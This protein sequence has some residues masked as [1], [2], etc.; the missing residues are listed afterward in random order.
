MATATSLQQ[1][2]E[3]VRLHRT[4]VSLALRNDPRIAAATR[5]RVQ[6]AARQ[7]G[8]RPNPLVVALMK[9]RRS[10]QRAATETIAYLTAYPTRDGW[11]EEHSQRADMFT[12]ARARAAELGFALRDFWVAQPGL[13]V[14]RTTQILEARGVRGVVVGRLPPG[15]ATFPFDYSPFSAIS[16]DPGLLEPRLHMAGFDHFAAAEFAMEGL[17]ALG[18]RRIGFVLPRADQGYPF[19]RRRWLGGYLAQQIRLAPRDRLTPQL[20]SPGLEAAFPA[21]I[22]QQQPDAIITPDAAVLETWLRRAGWSA[23]RDLGLAEI[24]LRQKPGRFAG[25]RHH[26]QLVGQ[27]AVSAVIEMVLRSERGV[28]AIREEY[29]VP[30]DW[31]TGDS[32]R[33]FGPPVPIQQ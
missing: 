23:P 15:M 10:R 29:L 12:A 32:V 14:A 30:G 4:T 1:I 5:E 11:R 16:A 22:E 24:F 27:R 28:P 17:L 2:A 20:H 6:T 33:R 8:Y 19:V 25:V 26:A 13:S 9:A 21:W 3:R 7:L 18:Y 31:E